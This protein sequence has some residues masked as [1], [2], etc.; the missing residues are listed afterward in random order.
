M[1]RL[2]LISMKISYEKKTFS[3]SSLRMPFAKFCQIKKEKN[4]GT[5]LSILD[6]LEDPS[7]VTE[8]PGSG[9]PGTRTF[10]SS[11]TATTCCHIAICRRLRLRLKLMS[12]YKLLLHK[13]YTINYSHYC[14]CQYE[15][16]GFESVI[17][18]DFRLNILW[19][20]D[21]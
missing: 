2:K 11:L 13:R 15:S 6:I 1:A 14:C 20:W 16:N 7:E 10:N 8:T 21:G 5:C 3:M 4:G 19:S 12:Y 18:M 9:S 17:W